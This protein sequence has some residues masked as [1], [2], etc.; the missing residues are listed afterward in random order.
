V[1]FQFSVQTHTHTWTN[2]TKKNTLLHSFTSAQ[3]NKQ[4]FYNHAH[5]F[6]QR[7]SLH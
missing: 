4:Q 7:M 1:V 6:T 3:D 2:G 5:Y